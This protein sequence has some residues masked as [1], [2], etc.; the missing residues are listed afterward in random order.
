MAKKWKTGDVVRLNSGG[1]AMTVEGYNVIGGIGTPVY[2]D[3]QVDCSWFEKNK[4]HEGVFHEDMLKAYKVPGI[5][6]TSIL[7]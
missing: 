3:T 6:V 7:A 1:P 2:S 4:K 5:T